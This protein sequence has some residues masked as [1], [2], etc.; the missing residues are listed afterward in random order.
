MA[1]KKKEVKEKLTLN[2]LDKRLKQ[3]EISV[4]ALAQVEPVIIVNVKEDEKQK[5]KGFFAKLFGK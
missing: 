2:S 5:K 3:I 1:V 4:A